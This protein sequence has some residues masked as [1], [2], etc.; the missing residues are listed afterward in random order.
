MTEPTQDAPAT[1]A[2][3]EDAPVEKPVLTYPERC[4][5][6]ADTPSFEITKAVFTDQ[7]VAE[8][9]AASNA[10][11]VLVQ[12]PEG[13]VDPIEATPDR[14]LTIWVVG[15]KSKKSVDEAIN[16]HEADATYSLTD[17]Q[18]G[19]AAA[20]A[21]VQDPNATLTTEDL[22]AALRAL[23]QPAPQPEDVNA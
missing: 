23:L 8:I 21:K 19:D 1:D 16:S 20:I 18:K 17:E 13:M 7:L 10:S 14:P 5:L 6:P 2:P 3:A 22:T 12:M 4:G 9:Q 11:T 15:A